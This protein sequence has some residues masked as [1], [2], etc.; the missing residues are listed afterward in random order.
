MQCAG[1]RGEV[2]DCYHFIHSFFGKRC[3]MER[4]SPDELTVIFAGLTGLE[5]FQLSHVN[6]QL[7]HLLSDGLHWRRFSPRH[8]KS[9]AK[10]GKTE[11]AQDS[12]KRR[13]MLARSSRFMGRPVDPMRAVGA[14][15]YG[16][17]VPVRHEP[18]RFECMWPAVSA[19]VGDFGPDRAYRRLTI[20]T[21]FCLLDDDREVYGG[22]VIFGAQSLHVGSASLPYY[23]CAFIAVD[24]RRRLF[25]SLLDHRGGRWDPVATELSPRRWYHLA[26]VYDGAARVETVFL[27]GKMV[28]SRVGSW[29]REWRHMSCAQIGTGCVAAQSNLYPVPGYLDWYG[30]H[31]VVDEFRVWQRV[32]TEDEVRRIADNTELPDDH[33][34]WHSMPSVH[35]GD[36]ESRPTRVHCSR[37]CESLFEQLPTVRD[38]S[39]P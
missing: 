33:A 6:A 35:G 4:L 1:S 18:L 19:F 16:R 31:G 34:V 36:N 17:Y 29:H 15:R 13:C 5:L 25:C 38:G 7:L 24:S 11:D 3:T 23:H 28:A 37:P 9:S 30:F 10:R 32:L 8:A 20:D 12:L 14:D 26:L 21:W 2:Q 39:S 22:G 27:N